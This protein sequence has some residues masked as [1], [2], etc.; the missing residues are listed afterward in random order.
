MCCGSG[1]WVYRTLRRLGFSVKKAQYWSRHKYTL[2]NV[3]YYTVYIGEIL[4]IPWLRLKFFDAASFAS[5][6]LR[7]CKGWTEASR[8]LELLIAPDNAPTYTMFCITNL[9]APQGFFLSRPHSGSN[10]ARDT[11]R[12]LVRCL[13]LRHLRQG[14]TLVLDNA[15]IHNSAEL[16]PILDLVF[17]FL[18]INMVFLPTYSP[19]LNPVELIWAKSKNYMRSHRGGMSFEAELALSFAR[20][21]REDVFDFYGHCIDDLGD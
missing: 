6:N 10:C 19:E 2:N 3:I 12:F 14:D 9:S 13:H 17:D 5:R 20:I 16:L 7:R 8:A 4:T 21:R 18:Q 1:S 15:S 11:L